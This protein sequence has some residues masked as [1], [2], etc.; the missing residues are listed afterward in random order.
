MTKKNHVRT[1]RQMYIHARAN[2]EYKCN[3]KG[4]KMDKQ[5]KNKMKLKH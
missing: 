5:R 1:D 4:M 3:R 2:I